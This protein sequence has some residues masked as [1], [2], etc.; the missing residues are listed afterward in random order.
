MNCDNVLKSTKC[1]VR[2][3]FEPTIKCNLHCPMCDRT[4]KT[5]YVKHRDQQLSYETSKKFIDEVGRLG[6]KYFLFIG[7]GEPLTDPNIIESYI[8]K[9]K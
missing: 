5:D 3:S 1:P 7:G 4:K 9:S 6:I 8:V 2:I